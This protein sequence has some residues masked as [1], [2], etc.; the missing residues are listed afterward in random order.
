[1]NH[2]VNG[3]KITFTTPRY[4]SAG[5]IVFF[6]AL[7]LYLM[8]LASEYTAGKI[9]PAA[10]KYL[11][12]EMISFSI[13]MAVLVSLL[14]PVMF[15]LIK[16]GQSSSKSSAT[17]GVIVGVFTPL[18]CCSPLLPL[19]LGFIATLFPGVLELVGWK[20]QKFIV[21]HTV[22]LYTVASLLL[23]IALY[24]NAKRIA[25]DD[26]CQIVTDS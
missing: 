22:E 19:V 17:G 24:Q 4:R 11:N 5:I 7:P 3:L 12:T 13:I 18:M 9:T 2:L 20:L 10:L 16:R 1:M 21:T 8:T 14:L 6:I 15:Y 23:L 25:L 26:T